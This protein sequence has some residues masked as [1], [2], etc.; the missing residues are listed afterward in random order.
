MSTLTIR[1]S[2]DKHARIRSLAERQGVSVNRLADELFTV[3][4]AQH[5]AESR[6]RALAAKGSRERLLRL[7]DKLDRHFG[8]A[9]ASGPSI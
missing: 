3:A 1:I 2:D 9:T 6:F 7:L 5:D 8:Q 4:I